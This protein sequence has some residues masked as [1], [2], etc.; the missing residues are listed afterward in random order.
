M[1]NPIAGKILVTK[2][3]ALIGILIGIIVSG[4]PS[5]VSEIT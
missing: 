1:Q 5:R 4:I 2:V 3:S